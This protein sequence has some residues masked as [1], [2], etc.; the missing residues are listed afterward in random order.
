MG[1]ELTKWLVSQVEAFGFTKLVF[2]LFLFCLLVWVLGIAVGWF[3][4]QRKALA[5]I[6]KTEAETRAIL[7]ELFQKL[8]ESKT[9]VDSLNELLGLKLRDLLASI[10]SASCQELHAQREELCRLYSCEFLPALGS[11][12]EQIPQ[13]LGRPESYNRLLDDILPTLETM[14]KFLKV[15]NHDQLLARLENP[16]RYLLNQKSFNITARR[17]LALS[18]F[19]NFKTRRDIKT[20]TQSASKFFRKN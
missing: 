3:F 11:Y 2:S 10:S 12:L 20:I 1:D 5:S 8:D 19:W 6:G 15:I 13:L 16:S 17:S 7:H 4:L 9:K 18:S 14:I